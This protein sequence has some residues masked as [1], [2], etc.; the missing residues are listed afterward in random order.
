MPPNL[1]DLAL[2]HG[3][4]DTCLQ[5]VE[6]LLAQTAAQSVPRYGSF[7]EQEPI[8]PDGTTRPLIVPNP[9]VGE[10]LE[11]IAPVYE[12]LGQLGEGGMGEVRRVFDRRLRREVAM[13]LLRAEFASDPSLVSRF[14]EE[15]Q[16]TAQLEHPGIVPVH[17]LGR[18]DDGRPYFTMKK[19]AGKTL[20]VLI[21]E[22]HRC[23]H[24]GQWLPTPTG[25]TFHRLVQAFHR[26]CE[27]IGFAHARGVIHRDL[28]P[29]N[30]MLGE[31]GEVLVLDWGL[32]K[33]VGVEQDALP[34]LNRV[35][36]D[37]SMGGA[38]FTR[39]GVVAGTPAYM[40]PEQARG[41]LANHTAD[42]Y[43]LGAILYEILSGSPPYQGTTAEHVLNLVRQGPPRRLQRA[44]RTW[45]PGPRTSAEAPLPPDDLVDIC[46]RAMS[47]APIDRFADAGALAAAVLSF[48]EGAR[49][50]DQAL[51]LVT[52]AD[53]LDPR[54]QNL[55]DR[56]AT[57]RAE[58]AETAQRIPGW[59]PI[60]DKRGFWDKQDEATELE[61][62]AE[63][64][65][66]QRMQLL[67]GALSLDHE[68]PEVHARLSDH[69]RARMA[70][71]E[72]VGD[73][74]RVR[75]YEWHLR[76]HDDGNHAAWLRG[77]GALT[78]LTDPPGALVE[79]FR[80]VERDRRVALQQVRNPGRTPLR[81]WHLPMGSYVVVIKKEGYATTQYPVQITRQGHWDGV[82]PGES[83]PQPIRLL[84]NGELGP[85][86]C[87]VPGGW[88]SAGGD[89]ETTSGLARRR[90]WV[91]PFIIKRFPATNAEWLE[92]LNSLLHTGQEDLALRCAPRDRPVIEGGL[93]EL[94]YGRHADGRFFLRADA[95]GELWLPDWPVML[96]DWKA[97]RAYAAWWAE[98]DQRAWR[99]PWEFEWEKAARGVDG[100]VFPWGE[101]LDPTFANISDS[102]PGRARPT[103][104]DS[105]PVDE[106]P[107]GVRGMAGN[108]RNW[109]MDRHRA[110]GPSVVND[111]F[112]PD[113]IAFASNR[114]LRGGAFTAFRRSASAAFRIGDSEDT[115]ADYLGARL[116]RPPP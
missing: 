73:R 88:F 116:C 92:F 6:L 75:Q 79:V 39:M 22:V 11:N 44:N 107:Y 68:L 28:K 34:E 55:A 1:K 82:A 61:Q 102:F 109:C 67:R 74:T 57:L 101:H 25:W 21:V 24:D 46:E 53:A 106:S 51:E 95:K 40:P 114:T 43:A 105:F 63:A 38:H 17:A 50:R 69:Y 48:L 13:K 115:R 36:T 20:S 59:S 84:R 83:E 2:Q 47:R 86:D 19:V 62:Q 96:I 85:D 110:D 32:A 58:A 5:D 29:D 80:C 111:R 87:Y 60:A 90:L 113:E 72:A 10:G 65:R 100:R 108:V 23:A 56:A 97:A 66:V 26:V 52:Q 76:A 14:S 71:S 49:T 8:G 91:D 81:A 64:H 37:R 12:D 98:R 112:V 7:T 31:Y 94:V 78:L 4:S 54:I 70:A 18:T 104:V 77:D 27:A 99:L 93:G 89:P 33:V 41:E 15:A 42:V 103:I 3:W 16:A 30:M 9:K 45:T 35:Q